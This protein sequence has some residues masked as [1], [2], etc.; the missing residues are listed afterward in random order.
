MFLNNIK[1]MIEMSNLSGKVVLISGAS[2]GIGRGIAVEFAK[3][4]A[5]VI[6]NYRDNY[7]SAI[8]TK[9]Q[10]E[11][12]GGYGYIIKGDISS[13]EECKR[14]VDD[15]LFKFGK[16]DVLVNNAGISL[17]NVFSFCTEDDFD[18]I[19]GTNLKGT[20]NLTHNVVKHMIERKKG[21]IINI[22]SIWGEVGASCEVLYSTSKGGINAFTK[23]LGKELAPSNIRVNA[24]CPGVIDTEMNN[25]FSKEEKESLLEDIPMGRMGSS[26]EIGKI[27]VF[28]AKDESLYMTSQIIRVDG[29]F[30]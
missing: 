4:S 15:V 5:T 16:I 30:I 25:C 10:I 24:I 19:L 21:S 28:L 7:E 1:G 20:L 18:N 14:I 12:L 6:I 29:G 8:N 26:E 3:E 9:E 2:R 23:A 17:I 27:A 13:Y 22:S 11:D